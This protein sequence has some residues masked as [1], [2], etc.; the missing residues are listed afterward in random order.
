MFIILV[1]LVVPEIVEGLLVNAVLEQQSK[2][3]ITQER[4]QEGVLVSGVF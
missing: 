3:L 1:L 2:M 4:L